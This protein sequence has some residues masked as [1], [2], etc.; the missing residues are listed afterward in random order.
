MAI[1][2][3]VSG[4]QEQAKLRKSLNS[5]GNI[6]L[7]TIMQPRM[8]LYIALAVASQVKISLEQLTEG[9]LIEGLIF[10]PSHFK[11]SK[12]YHITSLYFQT[13]A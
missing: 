3:K 5:D 1:L 6:M 4:K 13:L 8:K 10:S 12:K 9:R 11:K 7:F 2:Q